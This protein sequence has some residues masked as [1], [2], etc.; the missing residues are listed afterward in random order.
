M[1]NILSLPIPC[2]F[3][4]TPSLCHTKNYIQPDALH[5]QKPS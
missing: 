1:V 2:T 4:L 5:S 3:Q